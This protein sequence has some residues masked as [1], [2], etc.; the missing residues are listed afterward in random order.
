MQRAVSHLTFEGVEQLTV[1]VSLGVTSTQLNV[2]NDDALDL[3]TKADT[4]LYQAKRGGRNRSVLF[5][6]GMVN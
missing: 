3:I 6:D 5:K 2:N 1:S 4:A